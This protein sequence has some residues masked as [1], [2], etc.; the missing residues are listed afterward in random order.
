[1]CL[2]CSKQAVCSWAAFSKATV[3]Q[4]NEATTALSC[5]TV[6]SAGLLFEGSWTSE[7]PLWSL[8]GSKHLIWG[9]TEL[10]SLRK[11]G[12]G[13]ANLPVYINTGLEQRRRVQKMDPDSLTWQE[14]VM[15]KVNY[16]K[17]HIHITVMFSTT[18][19][20]KQWNWLCRKACG[21]SILGETQ[22]P[23]G[24]D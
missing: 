2:P 1:M 3:Y 17:S 16:S 20:V 7:G 18:R 24:H 12:W 14:A 23:T 6:P 10:G 21:V 5:R 13:G 22:N 4:L 11:E 8:K 15:H 9:E 19:R